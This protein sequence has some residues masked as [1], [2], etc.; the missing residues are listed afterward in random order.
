MY[1]KQE[2]FE[3]YFEV[4]VVDDG[5][6][7]ETWSYLSKYKSFR[8]NLSAYRQSNKGPAKA[9]NLAITHA[10]GKYLL[11][12]GDDIIPCKNFLLKH[13]QAH[14]SSPDAIAI[15][16]QTVWHPQLNIN[17]V[18]KHVDGVGGQQFNYH[19][20]TDKTKLD[21]GYFY[22]SNISLLKSSLDNLD[23][24]FDTD[25]HSCGY[26]DIE[27][28]YRLIGSEK[29]IVYH[30]DV[31]GYHHH[32]Y[33]LKGFCERQY[34]SGTMACILKE[35]HPKLCKK[36]G[37]LELE[38]ILSIRYI[39]YDLDKSTIEEW[40]ELLVE[41]F[42]VTKDLDYAFID[43]IYFGIFQ[44]FFYKGM[45]DILYS[46]KEMNSALLC[47][48]DIYL[49]PAIIKY[50]NYGRNNIEDTTI[51][52]LN[53]IISTSSQYT[54]KFTKFYLNKKV[55]LFL[56]P[57]KNKIKFLYLTLINNAINNKTSV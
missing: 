2:H 18:M 32:S 41:N 7:D 19:Y 43:E 53:K 8:F 20:I 1:E 49:S 45:I 25:F 21:Y 29:N 52:K 48:I 24:L 27:L 40:E 10:K 15:L 51:A 6:N 35:K 9:R 14:Q 55:K 11:I 56:K 34:R 30:Q 46:S 13:Y 17:S 38:N 37:I 54:N 22:T 4:I 36:L 33:D 44:Y 57:I 28:G 16:G 50:I 5:S 47:I 39:N 12:T 31:I 26:E 23:K 3:G 42:E